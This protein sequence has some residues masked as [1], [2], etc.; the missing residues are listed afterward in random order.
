[1]STTV[2]QPIVPEK[3]AGTSKPQTVSAA[4]VHMDAIRGIAAMLVFY[5]HFRSLM[6]VDFAEVNHKSAVTKLSYFLSGLGHS[7]VMVFFVLSGF[8]IV[9]SV[10]RAVKTNRWSW[11]WYAEQRLTR[12]LVVIIP[13]VVLGGLL[14]QIGTRMFGLETIY[15]GG[16]QYHLMVPKAIALTST[17]PI[18]LGNLL[19]LQQIVVPTFGSNGPMWS[20]ANE[21]WYYLLFPLLLFAFAG[22][23]PIALRIGLAVLSVAIMAFIGKTISIYF[24]VWMMGALVALIPQGK[25]NPVTDRLA[26]AATTLLTI[27]CI[28]VAR[29]HPGKL[30]IPTDFAIGISF[31]AMLYFLIAACRQHHSIHPT[32]AKVASFVS[33]ISF[34]LYVLHTPLLIFL[35]AKIIGSGERWQPDIKHTAIGLGI[36]AV[37]FVYVY[38][39]WLVT[40]ARTATVRHA[41]HDMFTKKEA[42]VAV[43]SE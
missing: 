19:F 18:A 41:I 23:Q 34:S 39:I 27:G 26:L 16:G 5:E 25:E 12:L 4:S 8:F 33:G 32:Y 28:G 20:L 35:N 15:G 42:P 9:S 29:L 30:P 13:A 37:A 17:L 2:D 14:D 22:K 36:A 38:L 24:A 31:A 21:F 11:G 7:A 3:E 40:E 43:P 10:M 6:F 1:M